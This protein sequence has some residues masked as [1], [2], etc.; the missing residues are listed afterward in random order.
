MSHYPAASKIF[1]YY[2]AGFRR[3][4]AI[5]TRDGLVVTHWP[6]ERDSFDFRVSPDQKVRDITK[7]RAIV[8]PSGY[9]AE[10]FP[11]DPGKDFDGAFEFTAPEAMHNGEIIRPDWVRL[12]VAAT[13]TLEEELHSEKKAREDATKDVLISTNAYLMGLAEVPPD[14][15]QDRVIAELEAATEEFSKLLDNNPEDE[16][17]ILQPYLSI[18]R[19]KILLEPSAVT[20]TPEVEIGLGSRKHRMDFVIEL[21]GRR[22]VLVEIEKPGLKVFTKEDQV[23]AEVTHAQQQVEDWINW[24][25]DHQS[26]AREEILPGVREPQGW[27]IIGRRSSMTESQQRAL[28][29]RNAR[30][31][32]ITIMTYDDLLDKA[33]Q[34]LENLRQLVQ[35]A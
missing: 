17:S 30:L 7:D 10:F 32:D 20:I 14:Q 22:Y 6:A 21:P 34:H 12:D 33:R 16:R 3:I 23:T 25:R 2:L 29:G 31:Q 4:T 24:I 19:N 35:D 9:R 26:V 8:Y 27:V 1:P 11:D 13:H 28:D 5:L 18:P 15:K